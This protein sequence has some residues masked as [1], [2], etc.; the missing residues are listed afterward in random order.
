MADADATQDAAGAKASED[1]T[2]GEG[3]QASGA[4]ADTKPPTSAEA[5]RSSSR[6]AAQRKQYKEEKEKKKGSKDEMVLPNQ[7]AK[8]A[9]E[10]QALEQTTAG[11]AGSIRR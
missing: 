10:D 3:E 7:E 11:S 4:A 1:A 2:A 6:Q 9:K 8:V 5:Q